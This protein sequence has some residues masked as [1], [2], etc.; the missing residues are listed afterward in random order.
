VGGVGAPAFTTAQARQ[1]GRF[2][3]DLRIDVSA[4]RGERTIVAVDVQLLNSQR[5]SVGASSTVPLEEVI[6][7]LEGTSF[8]LIEGTFERFS[9]VT[10]AR[11]SLLDEN[12]TS[13][14]PR[15]ITITRQPTVAS[16]GACDA[17][18]VMNRCTAGL[19]C[20]G[21][22]PNKCQTG[23]APV[24]TRLGYF[25]D[26][27]GARV[28]FEGTDADADVVGYRMQFL[29][30]SGDPVFINH[31]SED[32]SAPV[33]EATY[34]V[35]PQTGST[36]F[37]RLVPSDVLL[38]GVAS[39][40]VN[41]VDD[42]DLPSNS[43]VAE[44]SEAP[45]RGLGASCDE[46]SFNRCSDGG[47]CTDF[48][49]QHR[50]ALPSEAQQ[51]S[52]SAAL[53]LNPATGGARVRGSLRSSLWEPP[54]GCSSLRPQQPDR[55]VKLVL[56]Q[57]ATKL[58]LSTDH[59]YTGFDTELYLLTSCAAAP[60]LSWCNADQ[61]APSTNVHAVLTLQNVAA[62]EYYVVV[63]SFPSPAFEATSDTFELTAT[64]E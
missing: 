17:T 18:F 24:L 8:A 32:S 20:R 39:V 52:C 44:R 41:A 46:R 45:T 53:G 30:E 23:V 16:G 49:D 25:V 51:S 63:D 13:S 21:P 10:T 59:P 26:E 60:T 64:V 15:E 2:G 22:T 62:G 48:G 43:L 47:S 50:C 35:A 54:L 1:V 38:T 37:V 6:T 28:V 7:T 55:V 33:S 34:A 58:T 57:A 31:D 19:G 42:A 11:I 14:T 12:G 3:G 4:V 61:P 36:F 56:T 27:L 40:R 5:A 9:E 29:D